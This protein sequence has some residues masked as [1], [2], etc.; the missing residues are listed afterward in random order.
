MIRSVVKVA[1]AIVLCAAVLPGAR[2]ETPE[3]LFDRGNSA[4]E[5]GRFGE[6]ANAVRRGR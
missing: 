6:A 3:E 5:Q 2:A 1:G 4:Y